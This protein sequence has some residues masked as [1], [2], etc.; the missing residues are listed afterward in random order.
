MKIR[1][2]ATNCGFNQDKSCQKKNVKV[3][4]VFSRSKLGTFCQS[5]KNPLHTINFETEYANEIN[6][7]KDL[8]KPYLMCNAN[9]CKYNENLSCKAEVV[10]IS[11]E[12]AKYRSETECETF[13]LK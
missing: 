11:K 4:G 2:M 3:E 9:Y 12:N 10:N 1:C 13:T 7:I 5:F 8:N 6:P